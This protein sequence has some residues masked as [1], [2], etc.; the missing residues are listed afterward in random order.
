MS[1]KRAPDGTAR[2]TPTAEETEIAPLRRCAGLDHPDLVVEPLRRSRATPCFQSRPNDDR[3]CRRTF[4]RASSVATLERGAPV[5]EEA[6]C[7]TLMV[8]TPQLTERF[9]EQVG[10]VQSLVGPQL[11]S[12]GR[13]GLLGDQRLQHVVRFG[14]AP[15]KGG[16]RDTF[17]RST[18][19][20]DRP[21]Q[22]SFCVLR[23]P[24][25][26]RSLEVRR[27]ALAPCGGRVFRVSHGCRGCSGGRQRIR[28]VLV[29]P[30][31]AFEDAEVDQVD[32]TEGKHD[33][34]QCPSR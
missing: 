11:K 31:G 14:C 10:G 17:P 20:P 7:P 34:T 27:S 13:G 16:N 21:W 33:Q 5:L 4:H 12:S 23:Q 30:G 8:V 24:S 2:E 3:S 25:P 18:T 26:G 6:P 9:L 29:R 15:W 19:S 32:D 22:S 1:D 28:A